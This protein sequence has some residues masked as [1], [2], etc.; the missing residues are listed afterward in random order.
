[1]AEYMKHHCLT[2]HNYVKCDA[3][4]N[5]CEKLLKRLATPVEGLRSLTAWSCR[6][7]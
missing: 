5:V 2:P 7:A 1:V 4:L 6:V 3:H